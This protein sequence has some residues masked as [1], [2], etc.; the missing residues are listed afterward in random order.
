[1]IL[2]V[3]TSPDYVVKNKFLLD[4][5]KLSVNFIHNI[6]YITN[7]NISYKYYM[8]R[9]LKKKRHTAGHPSH[10]QV[11]FL[12]ITDQTPN[13]LRS[14]SLV[15][16]G[17]NLRHNDIPLKTREKTCHFHCVIE[18]T[19]FFTD[20]NIIVVLRHTAMRR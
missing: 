19:T 18:A 10:R 13:T 9:L 4:E 3:K 20:I 15:Q 12:H 6:P 16:W 8:C 11:G 5:L 17:S 2:P 14:H 1:M 7:D